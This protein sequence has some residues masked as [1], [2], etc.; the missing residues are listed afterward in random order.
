[1]NHTNRMA[2]VGTSREHA[3]VDKM[4][5]PTILA[6]CGPV[7]AHEKRT[8]QM[9]SPPGPAPGTKYLS[10]RRSANYNGGTH[11]D[12]TL[13]RPALCD[14]IQPAYRPKKRNSSEPAFCSR[15]DTRLAAVD[16]LS[17][18]AAAWFSRLPVRIPRC[19]VGMQT[20]RLPMASELANRRNTGWLRKTSAHRA[21]VGPNES[22]H[23]FLR[24]HTC[25]PPRRR[26]G[27]CRTRT[28]RRG[29]AAWAGSRRRL[30]SS[31][32]CPP[33]PRTIRPTA[34]PSLEG[35][36]SRGARARRWSCRPRALQ[37][38]HTQQ[39]S[40]SGPYDCPQMSRGR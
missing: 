12:S 9:R 28:R 27:C 4:Y 1:M 33:A 15:F 8:T 32:A 35:R 10:V 22:R 38:G 13:A 11:C 24:M 31:P 26:P 37:R 25:W 18:R 34:R 2:E 16:G 20:H 30:S 36:R 5:G 17:G 14:H 7:Q 3:I 23:V 40:A 39:V 21:A 29:A 19:C 6:T